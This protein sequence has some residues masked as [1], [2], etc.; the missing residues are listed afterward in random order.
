MQW[1]P[2]AHTARAWTEPEKRYS[3]IEK[4]SLALYSRVVSNK[5]YLLGSKFEAVVDHQPLLPLYNRPARPKQMR[6]D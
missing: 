1:R 6:V 2:V 5:M 3:Q 4:E